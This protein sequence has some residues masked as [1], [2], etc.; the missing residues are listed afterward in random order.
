MRRKFPPEEIENHRMYCIFT[1]NEKE[2][3]N[4]IPCEICNRLID[5]GSYNQHLLQCIPI[6]R[7][8]LAD[9]PPLNPN[10]T[11][12]NTELPELTS[13]INELN[14]LIQ[15]VDT[16]D[17]LI[18]LDSNNVMVGIDNINQFVERK[19]ESIICPICTETTTEIGETKCGHKFCYNC[20]EEWLKENKKCPVC[21]IEFN[22]N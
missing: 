16:Y 1:I 20:I 14:N 22:E 3:E 11:N 8:T 15:G 13:L 7:I 17:N 2:Y 19:N 12:D 10:N 9:F 4:L 5:F 18:N 21:M 6:P